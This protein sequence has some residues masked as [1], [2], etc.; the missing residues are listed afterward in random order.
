VTELEQEIQNM[1]SHCAAGRTEG[2]AF[3]TMLQA[4]IEHWRNPP[5]EQ[6]APLEHLG[7][8]STD[9]ETTKMFAHRKAVQAWVLERTIKEAEEHFPEGVVYNGLIDHWKD[10]LRLKREAV[11]ESML[12]AYPTELVPRD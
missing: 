5:V 4:R 6:T 3:V 11:I 7:S 8:C 1:E 10:I 12:V 9:F 2:E